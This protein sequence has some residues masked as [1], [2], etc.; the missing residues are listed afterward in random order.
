MKYKPKIKKLKKFSTLCV[1]IGK[2]LHLKDY[3]YNILQ[4]IFNYTHKYTRIF[5][6]ITQIVFGEYAQIN[7]CRY[8]TILRESKKSS[9]S[10]F[11]QQ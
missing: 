11:I 3:I 10:L 2:K 1:Y 7:Y 8:C 9:K 5:Y 4:L 6:A